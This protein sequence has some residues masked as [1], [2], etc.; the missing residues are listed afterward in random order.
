MV[1]KKP[2]TME[3]LTKDFEKLN[4]PAPTKKS[5][6][7]NLKKATKLADSKDKKK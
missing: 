3:E 5:F 6:E 1:K 4:I 7:E 2:K